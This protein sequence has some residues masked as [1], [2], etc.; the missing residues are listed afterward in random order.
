VYCSLKKKAVTKMVQEAYTYV[1]DI[2][3]MNEKLKLIDTLRQ[4]SVGKIYVEIERARLT[5][6]L[7]QIKE[8][9]GN[10]DEAT[11]ILQELQVHS[12]SLFV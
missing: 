1:D 5:K 10:I 4:V 3:D 9:E 11:S 7:A 8:A 6:K 2:K 12:S